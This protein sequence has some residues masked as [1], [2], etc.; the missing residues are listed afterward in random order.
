METMKIVHTLF[1][2]K[3]GGIETMLVNIV[4]EQVKYADVT[5]VLIN[6]EY[7]QSLLKIVN[8]KVNFIKIGRPKGSKNIYY[9]LK[10]NYVISKINPDII[11]THTVSIINYI[12]L[13]FL[14]NRMVTTI[15]TVLSDFICKHIN[16]Y[17][18]IYAISKTVYDDIV[19]FNP[20][21]EIELITNGIL[22]NAFK[23]RQNY[24]STNFRIVQIGRLLHECKGQDILIEAIRKLVNNGYKEFS[25]DLIGEGTSDTYLK[26]MVEKYGLSDYINF[27]GAKEPS[28]IYEHLCDYSL[29]VQPSRYEGFGL[30]VAEAMAAK[31]PVLV[32]ANQGP[33]EIVD[34]GEYG[35]LF[36]NGDINVLADKII[37]IKGKKNIEN[38]IDAAYERV[39]ELYSVERTA[40]NYIVSYKNFKNIKA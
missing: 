5:I 10:L 39:K 9:I 16:K 33:L 29:F 27:L 12:F 34:N 31:V 32:S 25:V 36:T 30:T 14:R 26:R 1:S 20:N 40:Y 11:H 37:E 18:K 28:Y 17:R 22:V 38:L 24:A 3:Y 21:I 4:N 35:F 19:R 2:F 13:P 15:H 8:P 6:E 23:H 7:D